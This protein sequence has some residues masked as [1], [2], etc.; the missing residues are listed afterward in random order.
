MELQ[1]RLALSRGYVET[2][3]GRKREFKFDKNGLGRLIGTDPYEIDLKTA[4]KAGMEAQSLRAAAN[5]PIQGSSADII[6]IAMI[7][8]QDKIN[9]SGIPLKLLLQVHDELV[10]EV[11]KDFVDIS[12]ELVKSTMEE[13]VKLSVPL[14]V[15]VGIGDN[16]MDTK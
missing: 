10:L 1:E 13:C 4:R 12:S 7:K 14:L 3:L 6:K 15:D 9:I 5:A 16:W 8:L 2:I 11:P